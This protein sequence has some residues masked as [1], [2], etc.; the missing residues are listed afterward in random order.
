MLVAGVLKLGVFRRREYIVKNMNVFVLGIFSCA[1]ETLCFTMHFY[2]VV[3]ALVKMVM[4]KL[5]CLCVLVLQ[6]VH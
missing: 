5:E 2:D 6:Y 3:N 1:Q 4:W